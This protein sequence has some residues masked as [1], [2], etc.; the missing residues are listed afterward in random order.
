MNTQENNKLI[1]EFMGYEVHP[2]YE[3]ERHDLHYHTSWDWLMP[4]I[5][6]CFDVSDDGDMVD[7]M[8]HLQ[9]ADMKPTY[10]AVVEFINQNK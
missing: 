9:V 10:Q 1:A 7:I 3:D 6:K 8:H 4:V 2:V 5:H